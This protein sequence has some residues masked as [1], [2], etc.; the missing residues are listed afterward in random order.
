MKNRPCSCL[1]DFISQS[2]LNENSVIIYL[3]YLHVPPVVQQKVHAAKKVHAATLTAFIIIV[4]FFLFI[5]DLF[6]F[7]LFVAS[8]SLVTLVTFMHVKYM[9][10]ISQNDTIKILECQMFVF[11]SLRIAVA[12]WGKVESHRLYMLYK[13]S[14]ICKNNSLHFS[15]FYFRSSTM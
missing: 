14:H 8:Q 10:C 13:M 9:T 4:F 15:D 3:L 2:T 5:I 11:H 1:N 6:I 7:V 12:P